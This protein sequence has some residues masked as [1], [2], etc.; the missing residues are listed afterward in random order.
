[1]TSSSTRSAHEHLIVPARQVEI[2]VTTPERYITG[3]Y[4]LNIQEPDGEGGDW[5]DVFHWQ[6]G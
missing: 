6:E 5:H 2:P 4:A 1:M 3:L